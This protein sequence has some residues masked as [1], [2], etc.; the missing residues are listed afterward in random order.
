[1]VWW[2]R[3]TS[4][5]L[6]ICWARSTTPQSVMRPRRFRDEEKHPIITMVKIIPTWRFFFSIMLYWPWTDLVA[7]QHSQIDL[8]HRPILPQ[9]PVGAGVQ[10]YAFSHLLGDV[11]TL[12]IAQIT[13]S[14]LST[15][16]P[17]AEWCRTV[18]HATAVKQHVGDT[19]H[20]V[21]LQTQVLE[22]LVSELNADT[23]SDILCCNIV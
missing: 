14:D 22:P 13:W 3:A 1:M 6:N 18:L 23:L 21:P 5:Y 20:C 10:A 16:V 11:I 9:G 19:R 12:G 17:A 8:D 2:H 4:H 7:M 15:H